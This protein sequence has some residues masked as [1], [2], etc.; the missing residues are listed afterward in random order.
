MKREVY[1]PSGCGSSEFSAL[2]R[3]AISQEFR[4]DEETGEVVPGRKLAE[5][6]GPLVLICTDCGRT[7]KSKRPLDLAMFV[8]ES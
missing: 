6:S 8:E 2:R 3:G 5:A 4:I 1:C 7:W